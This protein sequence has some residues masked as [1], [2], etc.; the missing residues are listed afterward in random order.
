MSK[1]ST[2]HGFT[3]IEVLLAIAISSVVMLVVGS[4]FVGILNARQQVNAQTESTEAGSRILNLIQ[5]DLD[6]LW[7]HN[8]KKNR[9]LVA[10]NHDIAGFPVDKLDFLTSTNAANYVLDTDERPQKPSICEVGYWLKT[11]PDTPGLMQLWR[12]EDPLVDDEI[13]TEGTFQ[14]V[15]DRIRSFNIT[16]YE[17]LGHSAEE[18]NEWDS[19]VADALPKVIKIEFSLERKIASRN[20]AGGA[21][22]EDP[23]GVK[24]KYTR[25]IVLNERFNDI[26][27]PGVALVPILPRTPKSAEEGGG[28]PAGPA[29]PGGGP[30]GPGGRGKGEGGGRDGRGATQ[31]GPD[32]GLSTAKDGR[33]TQGRGGN[34]GSNP[35]L[36]P[37]FFPGSGTNPSFN[38]GD[39][40]KQ[41][42]GGR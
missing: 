29:G 26:L 7:Y 34:R 6:G 36:P 23:E 4:A 39:L 31:F 42:G 19:S 14:L 12:R 41:L 8:I 3:L 16:Y 20:R 9:V 33:T 18:I 30:A 10:R 22:L 1:H 24:K 25:F 40:L 27:K 32:G 11:N 37:G 2:Q 28:G 17:T 38:L 35:T 15:H 13:T 21:E 5:R